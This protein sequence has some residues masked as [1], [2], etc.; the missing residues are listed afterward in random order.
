MWLSNHFLFAAAQ[1]FGV[2][3]PKAAAAVYD[4]LLPYRSLHAAYAVGYL[5]P[6]EVALAIAARVM[7]DNEGALAHHQAAAVTIEACGAARARALNGYQ[8]AVTLLARDAPGDRQQAADM[9]QE[10]LAFCRTKGYA[11]FEGKTEELLTTI[12]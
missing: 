2:E 10:T 1:G 5:G 7:G 12:R 8:W 3:N 6:V 4:R 11:T 9:L